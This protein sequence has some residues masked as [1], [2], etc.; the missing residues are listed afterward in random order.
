MKPPRAKKKARRKPRTWSGW[1]A[2]WSDP[3]DGSMAPGIFFPQDPRTEL[4]GREH[5]FF[6]VRITEIPTP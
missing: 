4:T 2:L 5:Q 1:T 6:R 3:R